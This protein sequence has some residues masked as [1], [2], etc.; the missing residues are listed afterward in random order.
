M[1]NLVLIDGN[2]LMHRA[3]HAVKFAPM[4]EG[5]PIGM[6]YGFS[7]MLINIIEI[8]RPD[9]LFIAFDTKEKTF[10][11]EMDENYKA[12]REK[13]DDEFYDQIPLIFECVD[14]FEIPVL[15]LPGYEADDIIGTLAVS[16]SG[17]GFSVK[18]LSGD[19]DFLQLAS[20][21]IKLVKPNGKIQDS[22]IYGAEETYARYGVTPEQIVDYKAMVGDSSDNYKGIPGCGPKTA[23]LLL[24]EY[25]SL[26]N[27]Y[28]NL[29]L[30]K[31]KLKDKFETYRNDAFHCQKLARIKLDVPVDYS[32]DTPFCFVSDKTLMFLEKMKFVSLVSRYQRVINNYEHSDNV[33]QKSESVSATDSLQMS[34]F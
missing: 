14:H 22:L 15:S 28:A 7:S 18:I 13:A 25:G 19:L 5:K 20:D 17:Q 29:D 11:H 23:S 34:M 2:A 10:R 30:L 26:T 31:P 6:V 8:F 12:H 33:E 1:K 21:R 9:V 24:Q 4:Y 16:G 32:F 3:Y 27:I